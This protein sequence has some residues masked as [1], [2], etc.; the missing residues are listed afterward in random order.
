MAVLGSK[1]A[2]LTLLT[3]FLGS[4]HLF[5]GLFLFLNLQV[6][7]VLVSFNDCNYRKCRKCWNSKKLSEKYYYVAT[8]IE[9][10][11]PIAPGIHIV[12]KEYWGIP[13]KGV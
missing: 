3:D 4:F 11:S 12:P 7:G 13:N 9:A 10:L 5:R 1:M 2:V 8:S 6:S